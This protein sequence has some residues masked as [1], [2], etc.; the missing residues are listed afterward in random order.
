MNSTNHSSRH[1]FQGITQ[2]FY[3]GL[4]HALYQ[5]I[6][7]MDRRGEVTLM[8][9]GYLDPDTPRIALSEPEEPDRYALQLYHQIAG[10]LEIGKAD[11]LEVGSGR[12]G[13]AAFVHKTFQPCTMTGVDYAEG[14]VAFCRRVHQAP[15]LSYL[16]GDAE[17]LPFEEAR[18]DAVINVESS[19]CY[20]S[21]T[22][23]LTEVHRVL[24]PGGRLSWADL[25]FVNALPALEE[26]IQASG[27]Q[28]VS[29]RE[30]TP[31]ILN[32]LDQHQSQ[33]HRELV[34][35]TA[36]RLLRPLLYQFGGVEGTRIYNHFRSGELVYLHIVMEKSA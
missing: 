32:S 29:R 33:R 20:G 16:H 12:G 8:N 13:G 11:V 24:R 6:A 26:A 14:A 4:H 27:L 30:I 34:D 5:L 10:A 22:R 9:Y 31:Y 1:R 18:F 23:F 36:P 21:M 3:R 2:K 7:R 35:R 28:V 25:R 17:D 15:G 19:H